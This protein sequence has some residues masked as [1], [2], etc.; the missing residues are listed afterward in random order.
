MNIK[1]YQQ[2]IIER[3]GV[4]DNIVQSAEALYNSI[5]SE[6]SKFSDVNP[7]GQISSGQNAPIEIALELPVEI[8]VSDMKIDTVQLTINIHLNDKYKELDVA[9][10]GVLIPGHELKDYKVVHDVIDTINLRVNFVSDSS[11]NFS[12]VLDYLN[13]E[14][15]RTISILSHELKHVYDKYKLGSE[16][17]TDIIDYQSWSKTSTGFVQLDTFFY[18]LY[19]ISQSE[20]LVRP[21][22]IAGLLQTSDI[23]KSEFKE[24]LESTKIYKELISIKRWSYSELKQDL[25]DNIDM[26]RNQFYTI[27]ESESDED[28]VNVVLKLSVQSLLQK[29]SEIIEDIL[30]LNNPI[31]IM[32]GKIEEA[33]VDFYNDYFRKR[34]FENPDQFFAFWEKKINF[35]ANKVLKKISKLF[36]MCKDNDVNPIMARINDRVN[37]QCIVNPKAYREVVLGNKVDKVK[38]PK[39]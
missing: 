5:Y 32:L 29:S 21:S 31:K 1:K 18:Y 24:F 16:L 23:T 8:I 15:N 38:Y 7:F 13:Q 6:L 19:V 34:V 12:D 37:G 22:E 2:F 27:P 33:D 20:N 4:P 11:N 30:D 14:R 36:D 10:W 17:L 26:I 9:S 25:L 35:E 39:K 3:L 28:V